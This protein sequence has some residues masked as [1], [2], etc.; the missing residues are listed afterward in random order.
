MSKELYIRKG[1][2]QDTKNIL[3]I[4]EEAELGSRD[5][6]GYKVNKGSTFKPIIEKDPYSGS[7]NL[8]YIHCTPNIKLGG[9]YERDYQVHSFLKKK[10]KDVVKWDG[11][12]NEGLVR[13]REAFIP[14]N[15]T[16]Q[17][18]ANILYERLQKEINGKGHKTVA[19]YKLGHFFLNLILLPFKLCF[20][21]LIVLLVPGKKK[22]RYLKKISLI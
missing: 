15:M 7:S 5:K 9:Y 13:S 11:E 6:T 14:V 10:C 1:N 8:T 16:A 18:A 12:T 2:S 22:K 3:I 4:G 21:I 20:G 19:Q 17:K